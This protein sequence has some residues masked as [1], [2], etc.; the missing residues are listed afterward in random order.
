[1]RY[2]YKEVNES[3]VRWLNT[4]TETDANFE[5]ALMYAYNKVQ[6]VI[7]NT[8]TGSI[9]TISPLMSDSQMHDTLVTLQ[10][11]IIVGPGF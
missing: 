1:M 2:K 9:S 3:K 8:V 10:N 5:Y 6:L 4:W 11:Y 7:R